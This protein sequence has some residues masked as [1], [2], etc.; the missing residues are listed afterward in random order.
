MK[1]DPLGLLEDRPPRLS[2]EAQ[3]ENEWQ[4]MST[5]QRFRDHIHVALIV[6]GLI[7]AVQ[8]IT[9]LAMNR[10]GRIAVIVLYLASLA[11]AL[12]R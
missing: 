1:N 8:L 5:W 7:F 6:F 4:Q 10:T 3:A 2:E 11:F 12:L 9:G